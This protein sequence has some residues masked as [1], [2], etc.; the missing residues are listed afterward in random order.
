MDDLLCSLEHRYSQEENM[1]IT[2]KNR[3]MY[4]VTLTH[5]VILL[6]L[7]DCDPLTSNFLQK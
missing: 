2:Q 3:K 6:S 5:R 7:I 1:K 4:G